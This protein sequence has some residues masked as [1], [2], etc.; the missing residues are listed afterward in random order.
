M[1]LKPKLNKIKPSR[2]AKLQ[3][4]A[5]WDKKFIDYLRKRKKV[6]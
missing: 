3:F 2:W 6:G 4:D 5:L 1:A